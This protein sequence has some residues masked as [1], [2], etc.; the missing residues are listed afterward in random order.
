MS[1]FFNL[2]W[3]YDVSSHLIFQSICISMYVFM[4]RWVTIIL[5][6][7]FWTEMAVSFVCSHLTVIS[8]ST[9]VISV[10]FSVEGLGNFTITFTHVLFKTVKAERRFRQRKWIS[11]SALS[12]LRQSIMETRCGIERGGKGCKGLTILWDSKKLSGIQPCVHCI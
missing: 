9:S 2:T 3:Y 11:K 8:T 12:T 4:H 7:T 1:C 6:F 5:L 10:H